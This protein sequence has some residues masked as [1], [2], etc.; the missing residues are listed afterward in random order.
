MSIVHIP[1]GTYSIQS[2]AH[3]GQVINL[4]QS[5]PVAST[6]IITF[7]NNSTSNQIACSQFQWSLHYVDEA[8]HIFTLQAASPPSN[9][10]SPSVSQGAKLVGTPLQLLRLQACATGGASVYQ[11]IS[12]TQP[13]TQD[14]AFVAGLNNGDQVEFRVLIASDPAQQWRFNNLNR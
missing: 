1:A 8:N 2:I 9:V 12:P 5:N 11:I 10:F 7:D 4:Q 14:L 6:P 3:P 13:G